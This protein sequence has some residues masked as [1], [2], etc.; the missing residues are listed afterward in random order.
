MAKESKRERTLLGEDED[1]VEN[2]PL[3]RF[4]NVIA[5]EF[6]R[7]QIIFL[8]ENHV[9]TEEVSLIQFD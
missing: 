3:E 5:E 4:S 6:S 2:L 1:S 7:V 8:H 9:N